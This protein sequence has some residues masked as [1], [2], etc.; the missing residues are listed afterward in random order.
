MMRGVTVEF[1]SFTISGFLGPE[2]NDKDST[3]TVRPNDLVCSRLATGSRDG[4]WIT[5]Y[6]DCIVATQLQ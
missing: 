5:G 1:K 3:T 6:S 2:G 4:A